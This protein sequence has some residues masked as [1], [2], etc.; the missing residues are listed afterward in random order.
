MPRSVARFTVVALSVLAACGGS[1]GG[2]GTQPLVVA[3]D[4]ATFQGTYFAVLKAG[5]NTGGAEG[6]TST[7]TFSTGGAGIASQTQVSNRNGVLSGPTTTP[8]EYDVAVDGSLELRVIGMAVARGGVAADGACALVAS[9]AP[10]AFPGVWAFVR[11][12]GFHTPASLSGNYSF[13]LMQTASLGGSTATLTGTADFDGAGGVDLTAQPNFMGTIRPSFT[14]PLTY[15]VLGDGTSVFDP[16]GLQVE[17]GVSADGVLAVWA[18]G[19]DAFDPVPAVAVALRAATSAGPATFRGEY[20]IVSLARDPAS[21]EFRSLH[22]TASANGAGSVTL[23]SVANTEGVITSE[24]PQTTTYTVAANGKFTVDAG[25]NVLQG[26]I[27]QDGRY[28]VLGGGTVA[29]SEPTILL[30]LRK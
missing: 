17:G 20:W 30:L 16:G 26:G 4:D 27:S 15:T 18:G 14:L 13:V 29:G 11:R 9:I 12:S 25:G 2:G 5:R 10:G 8:Y 3:L 6:V 19:T 21:G 1:G 24:P 7:G 28:A 22:G 23:A